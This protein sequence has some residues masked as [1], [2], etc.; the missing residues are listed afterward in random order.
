MALSCLVGCGSRGESV[1]EAAPAIVFEVAT[2]SVRDVDL[3]HEYVANVRATQYAEI[4]SRIKGIVERVAVDEGAHVNKGDVLFSIN[5]RARQQQLAV[6]RA[7]AAAAEAE[8]KA[9]EIDA[10]N[11]SFLADRNIV[12]PAQLEL[13]RTKVTMARAKL[14]ETRASATRV[15]YELE[16]A[17]VIA[18]FTGVVDRIPRKVG[19][20]IDENELLTTLADST[21]VFAY[22]ALTEREYLAYTKSARDQQPVVGFLLAD[23]TPLGHDGQIDSIGGAIDPGTG[24]IALRAQFANDDGVLKHGSSGK[25]TLTTTLHGAIVIPQRSTFEIQ[26]ATYIFV[27]DPQN[28]AHARKVTVAHRL[29]D[30]FVIGEG[31]AAIERFV[32]DGV[33]KVKDG[34]RLQVRG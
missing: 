1:A 19:S 13:A 5:V 15:A 3:R 27:V 20:S 11:T 16:R 14:D 23:G 7:A 9:S 8:L 21:H 26:G 28:I 32:V 12:S 33:Q 22:F 30:S 18:P 34:A 24:T 10:K 2:P 31:L 6:E 17:N 4:R 29:T 25:V